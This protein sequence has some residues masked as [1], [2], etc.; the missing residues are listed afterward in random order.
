[1]DLLCVGIMVMSE[2]GGGG[3]AN[4]LEQSLSIFFILSP[5]F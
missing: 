3:G 1:M 4:L 5:F 2:K